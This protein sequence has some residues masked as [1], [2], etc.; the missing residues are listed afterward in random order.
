LFFIGVASASFYDAVLEK[1]AYGVLED[2]MVGMEQAPS[3]SEAV[4]E[5]SDAVNEVEDDV[6][7]LIG[8]APKSTLD[9][10]IAQIKDRVEHGK[11]VAESLLNKAKEVTEELKK[12]GLEASEEAK[13]KLAGLREKAKD[14]FKKFIDQIL[15]RNKE[16]RA[17]KDFFN[18]RSILESVKEQ[19]KEK[20]Q[21]DKIAEY[22]RKLFGN[23]S[24]LTK[25]F[26]EVLKA[27]GTESLKNLIDKILSTIGGTREARD[28]KEFFGSIR[29]FFK[30]LGLGIAEKFQQFGGW[31]KEM[32]S[33]GK[34]HAKDRV[35][36]LR[37]IATEMIGHTKEM[38]KE[39][40]KQALE[41]FNE[42]KGELGEFLFAKL[43]DA[44]MKRILDA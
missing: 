22:I 1:E 4:G 19:I 15:G 11:T 6:K 12:L 32:W 27:K 21:F 9:K 34:D 13:T 3:L 8:N 37:E 31:V 26:I 29:D 39:V 30:D 36:R 43:K 16:A 18:F 33:K 2:F 24:A 38:S 23:A 7:S 5:D 41:Y 44:L 35:G 20:V 17:L 14:L 40:A 42:N 10:L 25:N 28:I